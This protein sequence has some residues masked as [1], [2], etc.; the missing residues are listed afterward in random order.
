MSV[1]A[2]LEP[3]V[4]V[5]LLF[6]G[7]YINRSRD[8]SSARRG[9]RG[10]AAV[11]HSK[12]DNVRPSSPVVEADDRRKSLSPSHGPSQVSSWRKREL[13]LLKWKK[14]VSTPNT[15][16]FRGR[17]LSRLLHKFPFLV[18]AWYWA[19]IYWVCRLPCVHIQKLIPLG[20]SAG[21]CLHGNN[22]CRRHCTYR[23][24]TCFDPD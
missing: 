13:V 5:I 2:Y 10:Q 8:P 24:A 16:I 1:G 14:T 15:A 11:G 12:D 7:A 6:G 21:P 9:P 4:V 23:Q 20:L 19:L 18:E 17:L 22:P 3:V